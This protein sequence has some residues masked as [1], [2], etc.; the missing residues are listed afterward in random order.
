MTDEISN[1]SNK[2]GWQKVLKYKIKQVYIDELFTN[3]N[4]QDKDLIKQY[5]L[6]KKERQRVEQNKK[7]LENRV[8]L[9]KFEFDR[10]IR[11]IEETRKKALE[12]YN[13]KLKNEQK[14]KKV[15][16]IFLLERRRFGTIEKEIRLVG[17]DQK[18]IIERAQIIN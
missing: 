13:L 3:E 7:S 1:H 14:Q 15:F 10:T 8:E 5:N 2:G 16:F 6:A 17:T 12:I 18:A 4:D 11:K 9:L